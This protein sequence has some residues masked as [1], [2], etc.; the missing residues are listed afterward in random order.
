MNN[1]EPLK[2]DQ[3][4][5]DNFIRRVEKIT[6]EFNKNLRDFQPIAFL[7]SLS[8]I[9]ATFSRDKFGLAQDYAIVAGFCFLLA[10]LTSLVI[11]ILRI[12]RYIFLSLVPILFNLFGVIFLFLVSWEFAKAS[13]L[14]TNVIEIIR[15]VPFVIVY[16]FIFIKLRLYRVLV[17]SPIRSVKIYNNVRRLIFI[18]AFIIMFAFTLTKI[19]FLLLNVEINNPFLKNGLF[20][21][22]GLAGLMFFADE[23]KRFIILFDEKNGIYQ[24]SLRI[25]DAIYYILSLVIIFTLLN[26]IF[27]GYYSSFLGNLDIFIIILMILNLIL[28]IIKIKILPS[29]DKRII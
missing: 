19:Y 14:L 10:F 29:L 15:F 9:I 23:I 24:H 26:I 12:S 16:A 28:I 13:V 8:L 2:I 11:T 5:D 22:L 18:I 7:G 21:G 25:N 6:E 20:Y 3:E 17:F 1:E 27:Y 4:S